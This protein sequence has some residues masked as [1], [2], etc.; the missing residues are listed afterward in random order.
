MTQDQLP[1]FLA[2]ITPRI[3]SLVIERKNITEQEAIRILY[4]SE[5]YATLEKE[6]TKLW[7]LSAEALYALLDEE[8]TT[9]T[10]TYPEEQ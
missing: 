10:V 3:L 7:H 2:V 8:L 5:V 1:A 9:G 4:N 6:E